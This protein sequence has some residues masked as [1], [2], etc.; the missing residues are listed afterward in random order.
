M[1]HAVG[2]VSCVLS[3]CAFFIARCDKSFFLVH[4]VQPVLSS[5]DNSQ[6]HTHIFHTSFIIIIS[7]HRKRKPKNETEMAVCS[8][9]K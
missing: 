5:P 7:V 8:R 4:Y 2:K 9:F 3:L 1:F 6:N